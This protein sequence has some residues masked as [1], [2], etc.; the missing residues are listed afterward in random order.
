MPTKYAFVELPDG[1]IAQAV[2]IIGENGE[3]MPIS[4]EGITSTTKD[5]SGNDALVS[6]FGDSITGTRHPSFAAQFVY[7]LVTGN[8]NPKEDDATITTANGGSVTVVDGE[9]LIQTGTDAAGSAAIQSNEFVEYLPGHELY[10]LFT[11]I[12]LNI[13]ADRRYRVGVFDAS[14]GFFVEIYNNQYLFVRR[15]LGTDYAKEINVEEIFTDEVF[16]FEKFNIL[17]LRYGYL[18]VAPI[19]LNAVKPGGGF[20]EVASIEYP[21]KNTSIHTAQTYLPLRSEVEN[22]GATTNGV[23]KIGS[24]SAGIVNGGG[25]NRV[26][27]RIKSKKLKYQTVNGYKLVAIFR[28]KDTFKDI[29]NRIKA[30]LLRGAG[31]NRGNKPIN[32][33]IYRNPV[34]TNI[35][36]ATWTDVVANQSIMEYSTNAT[37]DLL[38]LDNERLMIDFPFGTNATLTE[39]VKSYNN[40]LKAGEWAAIV[41]DADGGYEAAFSMIWEER[42]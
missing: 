30:R 12:A 33:E 2:A 17:M 37:I 28:N 21:N 42:F 5:I 32:V 23:I 38:S 9:L 26:S 22:I 4:S 3:K 19:K 14:N 35:G 8:S 11:A 20:G 36:S 31:Y 25:D 18:G 39:D 13:V 34:I 24:V 29:E 40:T 27:S 7:G 1:K 41:V 16:D 15:K 10:A 6:V